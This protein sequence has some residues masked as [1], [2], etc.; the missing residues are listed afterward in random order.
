MSDQTGSMG[1][2][3]S[4]SE[5]ERLLQQVQEE[6]SN[7]VVL[8]SNGRRSNQSRDSI[9]AYDF[10]TPVFLSPIELRKLRIH[11]EE[12][13]QALAA[14]LSIYLRVEFNLQMS[15]LHTI[16]FRQWCESLDSP[17]HLC[18]FRVEPLRGICI[19][20]VPP[21]LGLT[22]VDRLLGGPGHSVT[23]NRE[24]SE[25][26]VTLLDQVVLLMLTEWCTHWAKYRDL[27][28][29][30][31]G[32]ESNGLFLQAVDADA[33]MLVLSIEAV[34]NDCTETLQIAFPYWTIEPIVHLLSSRLKPGPEDL[35]DVPSEQSGAWN[36]HYDNT[37]M[38]VSAESN[39]LKLRAKD[40]V[41]LRV[42]D[43][44]P[45]PP[46]F[47]ERV[48]VKL[49]SEKRYYGRL[50]TVDGRWAVE[51]DQISLGSNP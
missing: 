43:I 5:V 29:A 41:G 46:E 34:I 9:S 27:R 13:I 11:H 20:D 21:R 23:S 28:P 12:F 31:F 35:P 33:I 17:T 48:Q 10:R 38:Q 42:G 18:L 44:V 15:Q 2:V 25:L 6:E 7:T 50:G 24:L 36:S 3:L 1:D 49:A 45:L 51:I 19:L 16:S 47:A 37:P 4:Q 32:H 8:Q 30:L 22:I 39:G 40:V 26:E 14:R